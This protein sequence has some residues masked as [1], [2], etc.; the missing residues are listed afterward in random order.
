MSKIE[1]GRKV[2]N[3]FVNTH[4]SRSHLLFDLKSKTK[5]LCLIDLAGRDQVNEAMTK[6]QQE[7]TTF[8]NK[9]LTALNCCISQLNK[10]E[11]AFD[12]AQLFL[13]IFL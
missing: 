8:I 3:N 9:S 1:D 10:E 4:S 13:K 5:C 12:G 11:M 6:L 2:S 7:E